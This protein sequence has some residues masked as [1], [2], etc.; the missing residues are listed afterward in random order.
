M[1]RTRMRRSKKA[2]RPEYTIKPLCSN[3]PR[4]VPHVPPAAADNPLRASAI[5]S[6]RLKWVNR[7][8]LHYAF[9]GE[10]EH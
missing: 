10:H 7:T 1:A 4:P 5:I 9:F 2:A 8:V 6:S 3:L